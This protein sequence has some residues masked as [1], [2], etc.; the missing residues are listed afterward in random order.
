M[1]VIIAGSRGITDYAIVERA[2]RE[3]GFQITEVVSGTARGVDRLGERWA[4]E[5]GI[6]VAPFP[7][8]W[9]IGKNAGILRNAQMA[10]YA[11]AAI[12]IWDGSSNGS[13][14]NDFLCECEG[15]AR[16]RAH[17]KARMIRP[18][19]PGLWVLLTLVDGTEIA[20]TMSEDLRL[21]QPW[22]GIAIQLSAPNH[23]SRG[24]QVVCYPRRELVS[25]VVIGTIGLGHPEARVCSGI[26]ASKARVKALPSLA[27]K[28]T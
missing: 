27:G 14:N 21:V 26:A 5:H 18:K 20:G 10:E 13:P 16:P 24:G 15:V 6:P 12:I 1:K 22:K 11:E 28:D 23:D 17:R 8:D 7:A 25:A 3:S 2:I 9:K 4:A 19:R